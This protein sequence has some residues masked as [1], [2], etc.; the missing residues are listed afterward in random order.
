MFVLAGCV[1]AGSDDGDDQEDPQTVSDEITDEEVTLRLA[2]TDDP[3]AQ[4]LVEGFEDQYPNVTIETAQTDFGNYITSITRSMSSDDAPDIAQYNPG[5]MRS[6]V[7]AGHVLELGGYSELYGWEGAFPPASLEQL[8]SDDDA[9]QFGTGGLYAVPGG[10]SVLG[11]YYNRP[12]LEEAGVDE[13]PS[14]LAEFSEAM[15]A[16]AETGERPLS[17]GGLEVGALHLWNAVLNSVGPAQDYL[18][19]VYGA[20]DSSIETDAAAEATEIIA[21]WVEAGYISEGSNATSDADALADFTAGNAAFH[22]TGNWAA[23]TVADE[24]GDDAG[25]F[26]LPG[27]DAGSVPVAS[28]SSVAYSISSATEHPDV[29]AAFLDYMNSPEAAEIQIETGFMPVN[30]EADVAT[31]GLLGDIAESFAPVA[32]NDNIVPF[33]DFAAPGMIDRLTAGL[34][35]I[36]SGRTTTEDYLSSL[37][38]VWT[39]HHG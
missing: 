37:Q 14:T 12:M 35:G 17:L 13:V 31:D 7:P 15:E 26:V 1:T 2:Y 34:Q 28:G 6:L 32:E 8:M 24:M 39:S 25:F 33:P 22:A 30:T 16:V 19:W 11:V 21:E 38:E 4:A 10:L 20:P 9:Q 27:A 3:P 5:A 18:D 23:A 36:I 29:A